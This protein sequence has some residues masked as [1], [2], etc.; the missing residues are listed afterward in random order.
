MGK[1]C[2]TLLVVLNLFFP[3]L[4]PIS[5]N[6]IVGDSMKIHLYLFRQCTACLY[7]LQCLCVCVCL[8]GL[9]I[10]CRGCVDNAEAMVGPGSSVQLKSK[11]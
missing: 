4:G 9:E 8:S 3:S 5:S 2:T 7:I 1:N 10:N 11:Q 6:F